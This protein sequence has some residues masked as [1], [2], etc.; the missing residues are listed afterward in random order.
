[1]T[2]VLPYATFVLVLPTFFDSFDNI[3]PCRTLLPTVSETVRLVSSDMD[4]KNE[5]IIEFIE[6]YRNSPELWDNTIPEY[7]DN[8]LKN[9]K[10]EQLSRK[11]ECT[12]HQVKKKIKNLRSAYH[13]ERKKIQNSYMHSS[14]PRKPKWFAFD[15]LRFLKDIDGSYN[16]NVSN[17][18]QEEFAV[19]VLIIL[20]SK[21]KDA[22]R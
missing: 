1:M 4:W 12:V 2:R 9:N 5:K 14:F 18:E 13:R 19:S 3:V 16:H 22:Q 11:Y 15:L 8:L 7:K 21:T 20:L 6:D 17:S 10:V